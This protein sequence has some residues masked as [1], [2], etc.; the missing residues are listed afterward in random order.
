MV[1]PF[2]TSKCL[3]AKAH[4]TSKVLIIVQSSF[5]IVFITRK[6][7]SACAAIIKSARALQVITNS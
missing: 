6:K 2:L 4:Q 5:N 7:K 3:Y 1:L